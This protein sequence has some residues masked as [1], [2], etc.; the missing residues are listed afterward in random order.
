M[1][2][3]RDGK[4]KFMLLTLTVTVSK[5]SGSMMIKQTKAVEY[6]VTKF[7]GAAS[8]T[9]TNLSQPN[10]T[11]LESSDTHLNKVVNNF[12]HA[13][14]AGDINGDGWIDMLSGTSGKHVDCWINIG[15]GVM[16]YRKCVDGAA[17][18]FN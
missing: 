18:F 4:P 5:T 8:V 3:L 15:D 10:G 13:G 14:Q 9:V 11:W 6:Q 2:A 12:S 7:V 16:K 1:Q 17:S